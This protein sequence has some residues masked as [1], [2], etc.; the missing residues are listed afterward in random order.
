MDWKSVA[1][2]LPPDNQLVLVT[3]E[4]GYIRHTRFLMTA[5]IDR[6]WHQEAWH[7]V[8]NDRLDESG[9]VPIYWCRIPTTM[10]SLALDFQLEQNKE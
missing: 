8:Q 1:D 2:G 10:W 5:F 4:S 3:G 7:D 6:G 9:L